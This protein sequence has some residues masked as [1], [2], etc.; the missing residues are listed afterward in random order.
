LFTRL[1][2]DDIDHDGILHEE[3]LFESVTGLGLPLEKYDLKL[4]LQK[5]D[6]YNDNRVNIANLI[7][8]VSLVKDLSFPN[9]RFAD[10]ER[11]NQ[12]P[13]FNNT[14]FL[15]VEKLR[16][17]KEEI[18]DL[19]ARL[20]EKGRNKSIK[21]SLLMAHIKSI[22]PEI[23]RNELL[24]MY[25]CL[26]VTGRGAVLDYQLHELLHSFLHPDSRLFFE[27]LILYLKKERIEFS[28]M[29]K[30]LLKEEDFIAVS[31]LQL[32]LTQSIAASE[33]VKKVLI[34]CNLSAK[35][36]IELRRVQEAFALKMRLL[37]VC[38]E[39][40]L[41]GFVYGVVV[42]KKK[43]L[44]DLGIQKVI[45]QI[46]N[47]LNM[48]DYDFSDIFLYPK[49]AVMNSQVFDSRVAELRLT[50]LKELDTLRSLIQ[51]PKDIHNYDMKRLREF[52]DMKFAQEP[53]GPQLMIQKTIEKL[54]QIVQ[55]YGID[56]ENAFRT[57]DQNKS[58]TLD[59][60]VNQVYSGTLLHPLP[61]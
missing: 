32:R 33:T 5:Y 15:V 22:A 55:N 24:D 9:K 17:K 52:Y 36:H 1:E 16:S 10:S 58:D 61:N 4:L 34:E 21:V 11:K 37:C 18:E 29:V 47:S 30:D 13:L 41:K 35:N 59:K 56:L 43:T 57:A 23:G 3:K 26:D 54:K 2:E 40:D 44:A 45:N 48:T 49:V 27:Q 6:E 31:D 19:I 39:E 51:V 12:K 53:Q 7:Y 60:R 8:D 42:E 46:D 25:K 20:V 28:I 14:M 38:S 50:E